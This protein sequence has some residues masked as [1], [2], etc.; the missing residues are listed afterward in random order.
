[1]Q[2]YH[3]F[4]NECK[5]VNIDLLQEFSYSKPIE[6]IVKKEETVLIPISTP[7]TPTEKPDL[8]EQQ[9]M[10]ATGVQDGLFWSIYIAVYGYGEYLRNKYNYG[11]LE[12]NEKQRIAEYMVSIGANK[13]KTNYKVT[14]SFCGEIVADLTSLPRMVLSGLIGMCVYYKND[15]YIVDI[16]KNTYL[17]FLYQGEDTN[18]KETDT[19]VLYKNPLHTKKFHS[20]EYFV[21]IG[22]TIQSLA[23]IH[24][25]YVGIEHYQKPLKGVS[26]YLKPDLEEIARKT[27]FRENKSMDILS[28]QELYTKIWIHLSDV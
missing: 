3:I 13:I 5:P 17:Y 23:E 18:S 12:V 11:K 24:A 8:L 21:D 20:N 28:K 2:L 19:I 6:E 14:R 26:T 27:V 9:C 7:V 4:Y 10:K 15:I 1:M 25:N 16:V 22:F